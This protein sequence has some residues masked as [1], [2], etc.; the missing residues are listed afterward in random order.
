MT[1]RSYRQAMDHWYQDPQSWVA[2]P[3]LKMLFSL[4][5][6]GY[7]QAFHEGQLKNFSHNFEHTGTFSAWDYGGIIRH[8]DEEGFVLKRRLNWSLGM[9]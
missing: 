4:P 2:D 6:R 3:Y 5:N 9:F 1:A 8:A 7:T